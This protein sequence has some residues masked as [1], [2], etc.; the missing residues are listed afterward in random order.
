L[1]AIG[2]DRYPGTT[3]IDHLLRYEANPAVKI[4]VMLGEV[5][6]VDEL[7]VVEALKAKRLRKPIVA[8][9]IGTCSDHFSFAVSFGHAGSNI[10]GALETS[11]A[12]NDLLRQAGAIVPDDFDGLGSAI[13]QVFKALVAKKAIALREEPPVPVIP[14]DFDWA[15]KLGLVRKPAAFVTTISD[16]RG[17]ELVYGNVPISKIFAEKMGIGGVISLLWF[18]RA[19]PAV[20]TTF[21]EMILMVT[22]DH[23]AAVSGAHNTIVTARAGKDLVSALCSGLLT[24]GPRFGGALDDTARVFRS[25]FDRKLTA[26]QFV[27]EMHEKKELIPGE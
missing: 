17:D 22:A 9:C 10:N 6:G 3:F 15:M 26:Y 2:G 23:G 5:G 21:V 16:E 14:I 18:S 8:W 7:A 19:L 24:I 1:K 20:Y 11:R 12:K 4:I 25:A 13:E 27:Q